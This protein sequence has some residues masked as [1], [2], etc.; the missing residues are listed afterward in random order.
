MSSCISAFLCT[1]VCVCVC[2]WERERERERRMGT[3]NG[4]K[5]TLKEIE[6]N[7]NLPENGKPLIILSV[8]LAPDPK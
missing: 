6:S 2:V 5:E 4:A 3:E 7:K 1:C 8:Y